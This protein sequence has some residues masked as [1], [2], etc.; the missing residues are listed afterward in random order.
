MTDTATTANKKG[1]G[2]RALSPFEVLPGGSGDA[3]R[4]L[5]AGGQ[6][7]ERRLVHTARSASILAVDLNPGKMQAV[8]Q[9]AV[10]T[11]AI[12][13]AGV[14]AGNPQGAEIALFLA[15][16]AVG[17]LTG[18][19]HRLFGDPIHL[20]AGTVIAFSQIKDFLADGR[21]Q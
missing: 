18:L 7:G 2:Q 10:V 19:D 17:I 1:K 8:N 16:V 13:R 3:E 15:A 5:G 14:D 12:A 6:F 9:P 21:G 11:F 4:S 20:A